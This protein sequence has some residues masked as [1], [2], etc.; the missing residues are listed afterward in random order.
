MEEM[1]FFL[2]F[3]EV[4]DWVWDAVEGWTGRHQDTIGKQMVRAC[5][6]IG[7]NLVEGDGRYTDP[8][9]IHFFVIARASARETRLWINRGVKRE[10]IDP[11]VGVIHVAKLTSAA[12]RLNLFI[13]YRRRSGKATVVREN[14]ILYG[15]VDPFIES[16]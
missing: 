2:E 5:D 1:D 9:A 14:G 6:S 13:N 7:A 16:V 8:D 4:A 15:E 10:L 12:R 3:E 11:Q